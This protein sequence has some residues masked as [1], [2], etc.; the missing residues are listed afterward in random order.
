MTIAEWQQEVHQ[1]ARDRGWYDGELGEKTPVRIASLLC[2]IHSEVSEALE[3]VR[4]GRM[5][6]K[7]SNTYTYDDGDTIEKPADVVVKTK[8]EGFPSELADIMIRV[9]DMAEWLGID[10]EEQIR[11]K[12]EYNK[13][14]G[15]RHG[16]KAL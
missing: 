2:L 5:E 1:G 6:T 13:T 8:P 14:R 15:K 10:L 11:I 12:N 16:G 7:S 3:D 9:M 4:A